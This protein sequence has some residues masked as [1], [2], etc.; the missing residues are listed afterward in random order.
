MLFI[1]VLSLLVIGAFITIFFMQL[2][3]KTNGVHTYA[4][5]VSSFKGQTHIHL[6][7][8]FEG[9]IYR[10]Y[11]NYGSGLD[12][13]GKK[14]PIT[15]DKNNPRNIVR[16]H[17]ELNTKLTIFMVVTLMAAVLFF[18]GF[19]WI[20]YMVFKEFLRKTNYKATKGKTA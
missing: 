5:I 19:L 12:Y 17:V 13:N 7:Y 9:H 16:G 1:N 3:V 15:I 11:G 18:A 4:T 6:N 10:T 14:V 20:N 2:G 8:D